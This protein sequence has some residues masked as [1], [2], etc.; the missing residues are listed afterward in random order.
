MIREIVIIDRE[1]CNGCGQCVPGCHEG[2][3]QMIDGK[4]TLVSE[5]M[6]DGLGACLG[7]CP[8]GAISMEKREA[9][10]YNETATIAA[11]VPSGRNVIVAHLKHLLDHQ[12]TSYAQE[13]MDYLRSHR[14]EQPFDV[15][16]L[17]R[18]VY[19]GTGINKHPSIL[20]APSAG[21]PGSAIRT[22]TPAQ[23]I[24]PAATSSAPLSALTHWPVQM[25]LINPAAAHFQ[26]SDLLL[27]ADCVAFAL[28]NFHRDF[29][30]GKTLAIACPKLDTNKE[31][32]VNKII[33]LVE[34][35]NIAS[36]TVMKM[37]VPCCMGLVQLAK[38]ALA[39]CKRSIPLNILTVGVKGDL[40]Q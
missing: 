27:A 1:K 14:T 31:V 21:C 20:S 11:M 39:Q 26:N 19:R 38:M 7:H 24:R 12:Q 18:E 35:A 29:L 22:F 3:L 37:E 15:D 40:I 36:I 32:Y 30:Q 25:H 33:N 8:V 6:C 17:I 2:A 5:L 13:G 16:E 10:P 4:A 28:G 23:G 34:Q 9:A